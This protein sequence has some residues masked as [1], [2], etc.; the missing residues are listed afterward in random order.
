MNEKRSHAILKSMQ[1]SDTAWF[2]LGGSEQSYMEQGDARDEGRKG[3]NGKYS[4]CE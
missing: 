2:I 3:Q 1:K 4:R